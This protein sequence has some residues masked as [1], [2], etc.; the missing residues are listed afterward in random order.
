MWLLFLIGPSESAEERF[1]A[2]END[3]EVSLVSI[4]P[5]EDEETLGEATP[6]NTT[7][8]PDGRRQRQGRWKGVDPVLFLNDEKIVNSLIDFYGIKDTFPL[9]RHLVTRSED[10][11]RLKR[12]YYV[13]GSVSNAIQLNFRAGEQLKITSA[14]LKIFVSEFRTLFGCGMAPL[15]RHIC[16]TKVKSLHY[17]QS[18]GHSTL[19]CIEINK[20]C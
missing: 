18:R 9:H 1:S 17:Q 7:V 14:G 15:V 16:M 10:S 8:L 19:T 4:P 5:L 20:H 6:L 13:S 11:T 2:L 3:E 12:I